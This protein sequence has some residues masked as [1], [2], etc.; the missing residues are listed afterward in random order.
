MHITGGGMPENIP[1]V[2]PKGLGVAVRDGSWPMPELFKWLQATGNVPTDDMR[3]TFNL[4]VGIT[5]VVDKEQV[6]QMGV[7][8]RLQLTVAV[9]RWRAR[10]SGGKQFQ[11]QAQHLKGASEE[12]R[13]PRGRSMGHVA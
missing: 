7:R 6:G 11:S 4:G 3:R 5:M 10:R 13:G 9:P 12:P 1:R 8:T 2:I